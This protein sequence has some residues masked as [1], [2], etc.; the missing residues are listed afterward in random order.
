M[1][2]VCTSE[3]GGSGHYGEEFWSPCLQSVC[4]FGLSEPRSRMTES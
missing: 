3:R 4:R 2:M 1:T